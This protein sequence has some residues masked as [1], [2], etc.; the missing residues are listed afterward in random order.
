M[1][2]TSL[3]EQDF[4][5]WTL[6]TAQLIKQRQF[7]ELDITHLIEEIE[8]MGASER[9]ELESRLEVLIAHLLK[10][11]YLVDWRANNARGWCATIKEQRHKIQKLLKRNP[12]LK[13]QLVTLF[14][15]DDIYQDG[16]LKAI[17][18]TNLVFD[19]FPEQCPYRLDQIIDA[20]FFP[21]L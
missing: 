16:Y 13:P 17:A 2:T 12:S 21:H 1:T 8:S 20:D 3:Y 6:Q 11:H 5:Q 9:R 4:Y 19:I 14:E 18:E 15:D 10:L 7:N